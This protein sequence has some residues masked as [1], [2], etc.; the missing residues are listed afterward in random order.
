MS[1]YGAFLIGRPA[2][3]KAISAY[4]SGTAEGVSAWIQWQGEAIRK[5]IE[6]A[7]QLAELADTKK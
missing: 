3:V 2:Y 6:M 4:Q 1:E 7:L 5:G